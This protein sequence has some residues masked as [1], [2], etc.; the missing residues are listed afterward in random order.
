M[1][2]WV[3][4]YRGPFR[5]NPIAMTV[6]PVRSVDRRAGIVDVA[7]IDA[8]EGTPVV[9]VKGSDGCSDRVRELPRGK[10]TVTEVAFGYAFND[11]ETYTRSGRS[12]RASSLSSPRSRKLPPRAPVQ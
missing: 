5:P 7:D 8:L 1:L 3:F 4:A 12:E 2:P 9:D 6:C 11:L 10:R